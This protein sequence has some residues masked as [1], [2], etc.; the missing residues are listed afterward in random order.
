MVSAR[1][2]QKAVL[3][4]QTITP[5]PGL[6]KTAFLATITLALIYAAWTVDGTAPFLL[7]S[8]A[9]GTVYAAWLITTHDAIH[10]TL[11]GMRWFD[12][13]VPRLM[14]HPIIWFHGTYSEIHKL[15][16]KMNGDDLAD[17]ER[18]QWTED[19]YAR[20]GALGRFYVRHQWVLDIFV[21]GGIGLIY[22]TVRAA[23]GFYGRSKGVR[24]E[25]WLDVSGI[26]ASNAIL[27]GVAASHGMALKYF[28]FWL[29]L[30]RIGGGVLQWRAHVEHYGLWG[31]GRHYFET[32]AYNC[33]N[34][35][36]SRLTS[37]FFNHLNFHSVHHAFPR[38]PFYRLEEAHQRFMQ[39]YGEGADKLIVDDG[40]LGTALALARTPML[41]GAVDPESPRG[42]RLMVRV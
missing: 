17:P 8:V 30:E 13:L 21:F 40:Y 14:S 36:T 18:V 20:A 42:R 25:L 34:L 3:D 9:T 7:L 11:T 5:G 28:V 19:E 31:R 32:Q 12:E 26:V 38:V 15:H 33:R 2:L 4:L 24:R 10:H 16:H 27:Y 23:L 35:R 22:K 41:I 1:D 37:W 29:I 6:R 39:L